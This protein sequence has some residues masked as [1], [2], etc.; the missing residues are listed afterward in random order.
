MT[1]P[2]IISI[3]SKNLMGTFLYIHWNTHKHPLSL[4]HVHTHIHTHTLAD[5][6]IF[7]ADTHSNLYW[8][9]DGLCSDHKCSVTPAP[10]GA[11]GL[12]LPVKA[13]DASWLNN[14]LGKWKGFGVWPQNTLLSVCL[15]DFF[16]FIPSTVDFRLIWF[17]SWPLFMSCVS[18]FSGLYKRA[19]D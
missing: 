4:R 13:G 19:S 10:C 6:H 5:A 17:F 1:R 11:A 15:S 7:T 14:S 16:P 3:T 8:H 12:R 18:R 2:F 9:T